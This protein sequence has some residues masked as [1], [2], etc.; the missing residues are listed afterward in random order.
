MRLLVFGIVFVT[1]V[2]SAAYYVSQ[3]LAG[4]FRLNT[5]QKRLIRLVIAGIVIATPMSITLWRHGFENA[6][7]DWFSWI[8]YIGLGFLSFLFTFMVM[9]DISFLIIRGYARLKKQIIP[10]GTRDQESDAVP[11][12]SRRN[13]LIHSVNTGIVAMSGVFTGYGYANATQIPDV[14]TVEIPIPDLPEAFDGF[15]IV[16]LTDIHVS[17][18][19]K[20]PFIEAVVEQANALQPDMIALTGDLVDGSVERLRYDVAPLAGLRAADGCYFV[21]GNHEYYSGVD[22]WVQHVR[23][24]GFRVLMNEHEVITRKDDRILVAGVTDYRGGRFDE[25][26]RSDPFKAMQNAPESSYKILLAH[27]P[28]SIF[29]ASEAGFDLQISGH[30][31]GGQFF[32]WNFFVGFDQPYIVGLNQYQDT[33]IYVSRGTGYWGPPLRLGSPS[34]ITLIRLVRKN[35]TS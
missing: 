5:R 35:L 2:G 27:Q 9:R 31:H 21:T 10:S 18:T 14:L 22:S 11:E 29:E 15:R 7:V 4:S 25:K 8:G 17:P 13:F 26:H 34:E 28:K 6:A 32:P 20:R 12:P 1:V 16:Q 3:R 33:R 30:T 24:L 23:S 19:I